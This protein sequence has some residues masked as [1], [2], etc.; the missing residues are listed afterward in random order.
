VI[1]DMVAKALTMSVVV[2]GCNYLCWR[3][4][5]SAICATICETLEETRAP[6]PSDKVR[7]SPPCASAS[8]AASC[9]QNIGGLRQD[10][11]VGNHLDPG[12]RAG[13]ARLDG[14]RRT[15]AA[16]GSS[17]ASREDQTA[18]ADSTRR[19]KQGEHAVAVVAPNKAGS[20]RGLCAIRRRR[21]RSC[22]QRDTRKPPHR[23]IAA[24]G[25]LNCL[26]SRRLTLKI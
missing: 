5:R 14:G 21:S 24:V 11:P 13:A 20:R 7:V 12:A 17:P 1:E 8:A 3:E 9:L 25:R 18:L 15:I 22:L 16:P 26:I 10:V 2:K 23:V 4:C 19:K 6:K